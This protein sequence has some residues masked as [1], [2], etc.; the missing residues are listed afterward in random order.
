MFLGF[1]EFILALIVRAAVFIGLLEVFNR[2]KGGA[3]EVM[4]RELVLRGIRG[5]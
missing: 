2:S 5:R 1:F 4:G 3:L